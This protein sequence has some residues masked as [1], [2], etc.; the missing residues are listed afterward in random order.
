[1]HHF[2]FI[3]R[4]FTLHSLVISVL[5]TS[6][7]AV[8]LCVCLSMCRPL[9]ANHMCMTWSYESAGF[10]RLCFPLRRL[11]TT[12]V[13]SQT[14]RGTRTPRVLEH[15]YKQH[16]HLHCAILLGSSFFQ[17]PLSPEWR[18]SSFFSFLSRLNHF[19]VAGSRDLWT[20]W[21]V[22][23]LARKYLTVSGKTQK[24]TMSHLF[25]QLIVF[26]DHTCLETNKSVGG[27]L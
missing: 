14:H 12:S 6:A 2:L 22:R 20:S 1:M 3:V 10:W 8:S 23:N 9:H 13:Q 19:H 15:I 17:C 5:L 16:L 7:H 4:I 25:C 18:H 21:A 27:F 11:C 26:S 24:K